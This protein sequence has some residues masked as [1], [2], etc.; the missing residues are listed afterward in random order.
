MRVV[1]EDSTAMPRSFLLKY[2]HCPLKKRPVHLFKETFDEEKGIYIFL[3]IVI[4]TNSLHVN[5]YS[6]EQ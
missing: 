6:V 3:P 1:E 5:I 4:L 2:S